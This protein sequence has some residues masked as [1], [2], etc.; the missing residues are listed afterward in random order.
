[1]TNTILDLSSNRFSGQLPLLSSNVVVLNIANNSFSGQ[2]SLL[3][4]RK[5]NE[6][7]KL[8]FLDISDNALSGELSGCWMHW[9]SV[10]HINLGSNDLLDE[11]PYSMGSLVALKAFYLHKN[12][13]HGDIPITTELQ[14]FGADKSK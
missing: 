12:S 9:P 14:C 13:F 10:T 3:I 6:R 2:I 4:C 5:I 11:I 8:E 1:M 7:S